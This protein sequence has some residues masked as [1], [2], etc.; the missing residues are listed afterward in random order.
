MF[1]A[2]LKKVG[3]VII[4]A[5][6]P[7]SL[8]LRQRV[9]SVLGDASIRL[10]M[11]LLEGSAVGCGAASGELGRGEAGLAW[12]P[13]PPILPS[14]CFGRCVTS[15]SRHWASFT[16]LCNTRHIISYNII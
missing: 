12:L 11:V 2:S 9:S 5:D 8:A 16:Y 15:S 3:D 13:A 6:W 7:K 14:A 1:G 10:M 4:C